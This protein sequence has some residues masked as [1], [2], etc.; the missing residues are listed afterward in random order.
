MMPDVHEVYWAS[1]AQVCAGELGEALGSLSDYA[2]DVAVYSHRASRAWIMDR[3]AAQ[4][5]AAGPGR[6]LLAH[7][8]GSV[9]ALDLVLL[10]LAQGRFTG[11]RDTW[12][13][14]GLITIGSPLGCTSGL[15]GLD[16]ALQRKRECLASPKPP[17]GWQWRNIADP[18]DIVVCGLYIGSTPSLSD[19][20]GYRHLGVEQLPDVDTGGLCSSHTGYWTDPVVISA[21]YAMMSEGE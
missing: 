10:W 1:M 6:V 21:V 11:P 2:A 3:V 14:A 13:I 16:A 15:G 20:D 19:H 8:L 9:I 4:V 7:S 12:P 5:F 17:K 18:Q